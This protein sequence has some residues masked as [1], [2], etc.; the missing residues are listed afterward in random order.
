MLAFS[1]GDYDAVIINPPFAA[2]L[3]HIVHAYSLLRRCGVMIG[4]ASLERRE[5]RDLAL[6]LND[7]DA[8]TDATDDDTFVDTKFRASF[9]GLR[10]EASW[11]DR[12]RKALEPYRS[13]GD[14]EMRR[15]SRVS[16]DLHLLSTWYCNGEVESDDCDVRASVLLAEARAI[17][18]FESIDVLHAS[19]PR[20]GHG[21]RLILPSGLTN[22]FGQ[23]GIIVP[24]ALIDDPSDVRTTPIVHKDQLPLDLFA[25]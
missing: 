14:R 13:I 7:R 24:D 1:D 2:A 20:A 17:V 10:A 4:I 12:L 3:A 22:D 6:W 19:D 9:F 16:R 15:L 25:A 18:T 21:L 8:W 23:T 11:F 5:D